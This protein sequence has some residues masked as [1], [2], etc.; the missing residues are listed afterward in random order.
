MV[1]RHCCYCFPHSLAIPTIQ[2]FAMKP[3]LNSSASSERSN[4][5]IIKTSNEKDAK[6]ISPSGVTVS[7]F[8]HTQSHATREGCL[9]WLSHH[10]QSLSAMDGSTET[11]PSNTSVVSAKEPDDKEEKDPLDEMLDRTG[12]KD[13]HH[14][15]QDCM[16]EHRDWRRC[17]PLVG[18]LRQCMQKYEQSKQDGQRQQQSKK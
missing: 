14:A 12:C 3:L 11:S 18:E 6:Q 16:Y 10:K 4:Q 17:Q 7:N 9:F 2:S 1:R 8:P 5:I 13:I 15:L